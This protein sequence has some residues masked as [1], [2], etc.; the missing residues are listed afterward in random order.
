MKLPKLKSMS[1]WTLLLLLAIRR[2][3]AKPGPRVWIPSIPAIIVAIAIALSVAHWEWLRGYVNGIAPEEVESPSTTIRNLALGVAAFLAL[4]VA[5][6]R[7]CVATRQA[8]IAEQQLLN[9][10]YQ[11]STE[12]IGSTTMTV[13]LGGIHQLQRLA[14]GNVEQFHVS[15]M[16]ALCAFI[17]E[18]PIPIEDPPIQGRGPFSHVPADIRAAL[19]AIQDR[20]RPGRR[21]VETKARYLPDLR[22]ARLQGAD[23]IGMDLS[24]VQLDEAVLSGAALNGCYLVGSSMWNVDLSDAELED[25]ILCDADLF[26]AELDG[27]DFTETDL[28]GADLTSASFSAEGLNPARGLTQPQI[29]TAIASRGSEPDLTGVRDA[30]TREPLVWDGSTLTTSFNTDSQVADVP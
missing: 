6:W 4:V 9:D 18:P 13:R 2:I 29:R 26:F 17:R 20:S 3:L 1:T 7:G 12:M 27:A 15:V 23:L 19:E 11:E 8:E 22:R 10:R 21:E 14:E 5:V 28:A 30:I 24:G 16:Q 25:A